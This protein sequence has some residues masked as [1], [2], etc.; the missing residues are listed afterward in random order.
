MS[1][2][3]AAAS[4]LSEEALAK[5]RLRVQKQITSA[6]GGKRPSPVDSSVLLP[7]AHGLVICVAPGCK[8]LALESSV[9]VVHDGGTC[10]PAASASDDTLATNPFA[11]ELKP[12][13]LAAAIEEAGNAL[14][15]PLGQPKKQVVRSRLFHFVWSYIYMYTPWSILYIYLSLRLPPPFLSPFLY[16]ISFSL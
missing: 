4:D 2:D 16:L 5:L 14:H 6:L 13:E 11:T 8:R 12:K 1:S 9:C 10:T 15:D 7:P 3:A